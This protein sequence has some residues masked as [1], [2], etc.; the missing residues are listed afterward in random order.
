MTTSDKSRPTTPS[1]KHSGYARLTGGISEPAPKVVDKTAAK[2]SVGK[3]P[4][5]DYNNSAYL[6]Q[7]SQE[8]KRR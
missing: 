6:V 4:K 8:Q 1:P 2:K 3:G 7:Q 5:G